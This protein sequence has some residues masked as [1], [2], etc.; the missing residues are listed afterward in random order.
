[1]VMRIRFSKETNWR[2]KTN[3]ARAVT[4]VQNREKLQAV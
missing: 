3:F 4:R 1:M 2:E